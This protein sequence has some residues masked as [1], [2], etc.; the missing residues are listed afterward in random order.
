MNEIDIRHA[1]FRR[2]DL[3][4]LV[5]LDALL[6]ERQVGSGRAPVHRAARDEPCAGAL[7]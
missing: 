2:I 3:N 7:A 1:D 4:L 5:A 6:T